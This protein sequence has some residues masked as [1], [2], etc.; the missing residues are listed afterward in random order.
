MNAGY[1]GTPLAKK[2][3]I[4]EGFQ[5]LLH[6]APDYYFELFSDLPENL[7]Q[8]EHPKSESADFVHAFLTTFEALEQ[9]SV[10][11][12]SILKKTGML[13]VSWPKGSSKMKTDLKRDMIREHLLEVGLVDI[14]VA[15]VDEDWSGLKFVYRK[16][17][18]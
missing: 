11:F 2:L 5:I 16:K 15:A 3:G 1:S 14:K 12:K 18:R 8:L 13:W 7:E 4:K 6:N 9:Q 10:F 17:D